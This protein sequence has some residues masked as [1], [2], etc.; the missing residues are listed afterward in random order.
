MSN[1]FLFVRRELSQTRDNV[2]LLVRPGE[3]SQTAKVQTNSE[4]SK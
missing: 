1:V 4:M 2:F 3:L